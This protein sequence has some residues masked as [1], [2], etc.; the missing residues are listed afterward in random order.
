MSR[1]EQIN[2]AIVNQKQNP[3]RGNTENTYLNDSIFKE[4][5]KHRDLKRVYVTKLGL[6]YRWSD[7]EI[8]LMYDKAPDSWKAEDGKE[9][10]FDYGLGDNKVAIEGRDEKYHQPHHDHIEPK[11]WCKQQGWSE[12]KINHPDNIQILSKIV[13]EMKRDYSYEEFKLLAPVVL[14]SFKK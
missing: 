1:R 6:K 13:N 11:S 5:V 3:F 14:D 9:I 2:E 10:L 4:F 12:E 7:E 8:Q